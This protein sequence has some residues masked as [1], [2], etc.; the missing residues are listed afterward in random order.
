M[1]EPV[2]QISL[3]DETT[4][5][6]SLLPLVIGVVGHRDPIP[7]NIQ[8]L[9]ESFKSDLRKLLKE[10]PH[11][12]L[13]MITGL[14]SG[15]DIEAAEAFLQ[16]VAEEQKTNSRC[17]PHQLIAAM[18]KNKENYANDFLLKEERERFEHLVSQCSHYYD[19][20]NSS[21]LRGEAPKGT[22]LSPPDCYGQQS[23][24]LAKYCYM[25]FAFYDGKETSRI[26]GTSHTVATHKGELHSNFLTMDEIISIQEPSALIEYHTP[27]KNNIFNN[28]E[29]R[30]DSKFW[31][32]NQIKDQL[33]DLLETP[34][35]INI[36]NKAIAS[37]SSF[38]F[39][40][41]GLP[42]ALW[43]YADA[44]AKELKG[45]LQLAQLSLVVVGWGIT[46][47]LAEPPWQAIGLLMIF[48]SLGLFPRIDN[49]AKQ[50][51]I[52]HRCLAEALMIQ[53]FWVKLGVEVESP[54]LFQSQLHLS[55]GWIR[56]VLRARYLQLKRHSIVNPVLLEE[57]VSS[58]KNWI[59]GQ[60][61]W[62]ERRIRKQ[63]E[64]DKFL[65]YSERTIL[66]IAL[67]SSAF[68]TNPIY[69]EALMWFTEICIA[70]F[71][72][73]FAFRQLLGYDETKARY[74]R[75]LHTFKRASIIINNVINSSIGSPEKL[76]QIKFVF[77]A[78]G[79]EKFDELNDWIANQLKR[80][81]NPAG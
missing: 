26:G 56:T 14:S 51:F 18:P 4:F 22:E 37:P 76:K 61:T 30:T 59:D 77:E 71:L 24:F 9:R 69:K 31:L 74:K 15:M 65:I 35:K 8:R 72:A 17:L 54:G 60:C 79:R 21:F 78:L 44:K 32:G 62:L 28:K 23:L 1:V 7:T 47:S 12:P 39:S 36:I 25:I 42:T 57:I 45:S 64:S 58:G 67:C 55:L 46:I 11:T 53:D 81:Y 66:F 2:S 5:D 27:R 43:C 40:T 50:G 16:I 70:S 49:Q 75:S 33:I 19:P 13:L 3:S 38:H 80:S 20:S 73:I 68:A 48:T 6:K 63:D 41:H 34:Y 29:Q 52:E 10:I